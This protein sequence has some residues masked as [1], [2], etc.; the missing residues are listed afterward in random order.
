MGIS[1]FLGVRYLEFDDW[2]L[3]LGDP[4]IGG[5]IMKYGAKQDILAVLGAQGRFLGFTLLR[6]DRLTLT[7]IGVGFLLAARSFN[8]I[9]ATSFSEFVHITCCNGVDVLALEIFQAVSAHCTMVGQLLGFGDPALDFLCE[10]KQIFVQ[11]LFKLFATKGQ[12][13]VEAVFVVVVE[14]L[15]GL[16]GFSF[17]G[18]REAVANG[19]LFWETDPALPN[20]VFDIGPLIQ[21]HTAAA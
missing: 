14:F 8:P 5:G 7:L 18:G 17:I 10:I 20:G 6:Y 16:F 21:H 13:T 19:G 12:A 4:V 2:N 9:F 15:G 11:N 3:C 1:P